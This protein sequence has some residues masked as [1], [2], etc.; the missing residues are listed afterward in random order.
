MGTHSGK[1]SNQY[2]FSVNP[3]LNKFLSFNAPYIEDSWFAKPG[4]E[5]SIHF[6]RLPSLSKQAIIYK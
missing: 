3:V 6:L 4:R 1:R 5:T 2:P